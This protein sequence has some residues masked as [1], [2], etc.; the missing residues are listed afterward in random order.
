MSHSTIFLVQAIVLIGLPPGL[1]RYTPVNRF[2][3]LV[4]VQIVVGILLGPSVLGRILPDT[5]AFLFPADSITA[6]NAISNLAVV[7][8]AFSV[9]VH[10]DFESIRGRGSCFAL[11]G[12][13][14]I[15]VPA[16]VG[17]GVGWWMATTLPGVV[18]ARGSLA[19]F[20]LAIGICVGVTALPV[21]AAILGEM[22]LLRHRIGQTAL[23]LAVV[24]DA[25]L[26]VLLAALLADLAQQGSHG[27]ALRG[28]AIGGPLYILTIWFFGRPILAYLAQSG[29]FDSRY[30]ARHL[31]FACCFAFASAAVT[32][33]LG[34]H[35]VL[36]AFIAGAV[37]PAQWRPRMIERF[38]TVVVTLL[39]PFFFMST[40]LKVMVDPSV[41]AFSEVLL[42]VCLASIIGKIIGTAVPSLLCGATWPE[43]L[44]LGSLMQTKGL[45]EVIVLT[46]LLEKEVIAPMAFSAMVSAAVVTT[47]LTMPFARFAVKR[48]GERDTS[49]PEA[50]P[51]P[52]GERM[53]EE[54]LLS[55][56]RASTAPTPALS[57]VI[58]S[59]NGWAE[60]DHC[61]ASLYKQ[62]LPT[63]EVIV[64]DNASTDG[65]PLRIREHYPSVDLRC[66]T[67]NVGHTKAV[68][69]GFSL[70]R[71]TFVLLLDSDT[72]LID[73]CIDRMIAFL[74]EQ[75]AAYLAAPRTLNTDGT[76][77]E[78]ARNLPTP[79]SGL[80]GR[81]STLTRWFPDNAIS[82]RYLAREHLGST[83]PFVVEQ[84]G[85]A[86]MFFRRELLD[87][88]G[89]WDERYFGYWVDTDWCYRLK[90]QGLPVFCVPNAQVIHHESN[91]RGKRKSARR[92]WIFH[93][94]AWQLYTRWC[95]R[96]A[97]DPRSALV[98]VALLTRA[99]LHMMLNLGAKRS[100]D[101]AVESEQLVSTDSFAGGSG[102]V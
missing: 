101:L 20:C 55:D 48:I 25:A 31:V 75:S 40:G 82:R 74:V 30:G 79:L 9:G 72:V 23:G 97:W 8:F 53:S 59:W 22:S 61:L 88:V 65:T 4:V 32:D 80:F 57:V 76:V 96:G 85:G 62:E 99:L 90:A 86:C 33:M 49:V 58:V 70:A 63:T 27:W 84:V 43:A 3:P 10:F 26:W 81:Q 89:F 52:E 44:C 68:N 46:A 95:T 1:W 77:Q 60:L 83:E 54:H 94:G 18:G 98:G 21:L 39:L 2:A 100:R 7:L 87:K 36:G 28:L 51:V 69:I 66:L 71:G 19:T 41:A 17:A 102:G 37:V 91:A 29:R 56:V 78:T 35:A 42:V 50:S 64:I 93:Y 15:A 38:E 34:L 5:Y 11:I 14:S 24:N 16:F 12:F 47:A 13:G 45:M 6:L 92:I 73:G 67:M